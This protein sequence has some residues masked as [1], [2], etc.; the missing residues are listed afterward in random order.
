[1]SVYAVRSGSADVIYKGLLRW[2]GE[3]R[4]SGVWQG[5]KLLVV[6]SL[7]YLKVLL[8]KRRVHA[9]EFVIHLDIERHSVD[10][11][12]GRSYTA[13][14]PIVFDRRRRLFA[15]H[16]PHQS[17]F[18]NHPRSSLTLLPA[19]VMLRPSRRGAHGPER[20]S[21]YA[22]VRELEAKI[23]VPASPEPRQ[24][25]LRALLTLREPSCPNPSLAAL[26]KSTA[27]VKL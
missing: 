8:V 13:K 7:H 18:S 10:T 22:H 27:R 19:P 12:G 3:R 5:I 17:P 20:T 4:A 6:R 14:M 9:S 26:P 24:P 2:V 21:L 11:R 1:L 25:E 23:A 16:H 15:G